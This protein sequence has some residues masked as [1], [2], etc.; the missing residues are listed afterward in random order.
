MPRVR[1]CRVVGPDRRFLDPFTRHSLGALSPHPSGGKD[2][3][4]NKFFN[5]R[6]TIERM[7]EGVLGQYVS[8]YAAGLHADAPLIVSF[9]DDLETSRKIGA[10]SRNLRLTAIRSFFHYL[11]YE[12]P[13]HASQIQRVLAIP[14]KRCA[15]SIGIIPGSTGDRR[16]SGRARPTDM[17]WAEGLHHH[18]D[19][20][21]DRFACVGTDRITPGRF[22]LGGRCACPV[23]G[24]G[25]Q[26]TLHAADK[27]GSEGDQVLAARTR[28]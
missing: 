15:K 23:L 10:R 3:T 9:L 18:I 25:T 14:G 7:T 8:Q 21:A 12:E 13:A 19:G 27:A 17:V 11:A 1:L 24:Q 28:Q 2:K 26:R 20:G 4:M 6:R 16:S 5:D 22:A